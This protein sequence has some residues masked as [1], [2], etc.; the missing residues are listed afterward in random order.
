MFRSNADDCTLCTY[1]C[2]CVHVFMLVCTC[3]RILFSHADPPGVEVTGRTTFVATNLGSILNWTEYGF[4]LTVPADSLPAGVDQCPLDIVASTA[5]LYQFPDDLQLVSGVFWVR[6]GAP[7]PFR[8][9]LTVEI[10]HCAKMT[11]STKLSFVRARCSEES[12]PYR[13]RQVQGG[14]SFTEHSS[15]GSLEVTHFSGLAVTGEDVERRYTASLYYL[16][17][18]PHER[19]I[20]FVINWDDEIHKTVGDRL[21]Y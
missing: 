4:R 12:L 3:V 16:G 6:P 21:L 2:V 15:Y 17:S 13:F 18:L 20:H 9:Q 14:G 5:G 7:G 10:Q 11:S 8:Q 19:D 1:I